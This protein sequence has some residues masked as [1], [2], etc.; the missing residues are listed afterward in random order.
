[1]EECNKERIEIGGNSG[2]G[3]ISVIMPVYQAKNWLEDSIYSVLRQTYKNYELILVDDGSTDGSEDICDKMAAS[4]PQICVYHQENRGVSSARNNGLLHANGEYLMFLDCDDSISENA[5]EILAHKMKTVEVDAVFFSFCRCNGS[6]LKEN[7]AVDLQEGL[8][9]HNEIKNAFMKFFDSNIANNIGTKLYKRECLRGVWFDETANIYEDV[10]FCLAA[11]KGMQAIYFLNKCLYNYEY[12]NVNSLF[13]SYKSGYYYNLCKFMKEL[14]CWM[15]GTERFEYWYAN[16]FMLGIKGAIENAKKNDS[17]F[18][19]EFYK[20][21]EDEE[22]R[23]VKK[24]LQ[25]NKYKDISLKAKIHFFMIWHK[26][27]YGVKLLWK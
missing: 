10:R 14:Y 5:L 6:G 2:E 22:M 18:K 3:L 9:K 15:D 20:I 11:V 4:F 19:Q 8:Y 25:K 26:N 13:T 17:T 7:I 21:C 12:K 16:R 23:R 1:M 27:Y 24:I